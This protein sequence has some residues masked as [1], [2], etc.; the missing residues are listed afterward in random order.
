[1]SPSNPQFAWAATLSAT[2]KF[3]LLGLT[4]GWLAF[5]YLRYGKQVTTASHT[6]HRSA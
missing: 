2:V 1:V 3:V 4:L 5:T 6:V